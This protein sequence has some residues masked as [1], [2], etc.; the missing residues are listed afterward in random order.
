M[1]S[2]AALAIVV[3]YGAMRAWM[4]HGVVPSRAHPIIFVNGLD[5]A[6]RAL[7]VAVPCLSVGAGKTL[8]RLREALCLLGRHSLFGYA[9]HL[10]FCYGAIARPLKRNLSMPAATLVLATLVLCVWLATYGLEEWSRM[11]K[12]RTTAAT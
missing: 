11:R 7:F 6:G 10:P 9:V 8:V 3:G 1:A 2:Y 12:V 4:A 5:L